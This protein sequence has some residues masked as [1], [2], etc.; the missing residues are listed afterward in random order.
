VTLWLA[1]G[2]ERIPGV[3][4]NLFIIGSSSRSIIEALALMSADAVVN[5]YCKSGAVAV[6][7]ILVGTPS[8]PGTLPPMC[9]HRWR[10]SGK[11]TSVRWQSTCEG[12][13]EMN[14][15]NSV[16]ANTDSREADSRSTGNY[17]YSV[18]EA[19]GV[20]ADPAALE[21]AVDELEIASF[22]R[23][24]LSVLATDETIKDRVGHLY[25]NDRHSS[26]RGD[27]CPHLCLQIYVKIEILSCSRRLLTRRTR[28]F[29]P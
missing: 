28:G 29:A 6:V 21:R 17:D 27:G 22:D 4:P 7:A 5:R 20:F 2:S 9:Q 11:R 16:G 15:S 19:V 24:A 10:G 25:R 14:Q 23:A 18:R 3:S 26:K 12:W 8:C 1:V 13:R